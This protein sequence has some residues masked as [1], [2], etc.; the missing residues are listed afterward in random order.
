M[1][2]ISREQRQSALE[3]AAIQRRE[4]ESR[5][6]REPLDEWPDGPPTGDPEAMQRFDAALRRWY[7]THVG[8]VE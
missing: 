8:P 1:K 3:K 2:P 7:E 4:R 5:G 6:E